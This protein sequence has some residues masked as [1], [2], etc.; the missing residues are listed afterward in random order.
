MGIYSLPPG[1]IAGM[2][3]GFLLTLFIFSY[4]LG[5]NVL[6]RIASHIF[7][8]VSTGYFAVIIILNVVWP[9]IILPVTELTPVSIQSLLGLVPLI[10]SLI[11]LTKLTPIWRGYG[12]PVM[13]FLVGTGVAIAI[14]GAVM[15]TL[16][17]QISG[18]INLFEI[19]LTGLEQGSYW[20]VVAESVLILLAT[21]STLIYFQFSSKNQPGNLSGRITLQK[22]IANLGEI[23]IAITFGTIFAKILIAALTAFVGSVNEIITAFTKI[24]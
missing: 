1:E 21:L 2:V 15:G 16:L 18:T 17:P 6:F 23:F 13:A 24:F 7:I 4:L 11:L 8:G 22:R 3:I 10:L 12:S 19:Q 5:D 9:R 20:V 14:G